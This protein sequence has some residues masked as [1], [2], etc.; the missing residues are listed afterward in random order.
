MSVQV[1]PRMPPLIVSLLLTAGLAAYGIRYYQ[2]RGHESSLLAF[3]S[4]MCILSVSL[5]VETLLHAVTAPGLKLLGFNYLN[6]VG[7]WLSA[8]GFLWFT[9]AYSNS[10]GWLNQWLLAI[11]VA[12]PLV[13]ALP[14]VFAPEYLYTVDG[15]VTQGPMTILGITFQEW[16]L[17]DRTIKQPFLFMIVSVTVVV[18]LGIGVLGRYLYQYRGELY[19]G[20][21][22]AV[23]IG[24]GSPLLTG[25]LLISGLL[26]P[27]ASIT[28]IAYGITAVGFA[29]AIF[30]YR[31]FG[32]APIGRQQLV[33]E[34]AD[35]VIMLDR[36]SHVVD[37][38]PAATALVGEPG[39]WTGLPAA[40]FFSSL[41]SN[42]RRVLLED[43]DITEVSIEF[44]DTIRYFAPDISIIR[45]S[46]GAPKG[47]LIVLRE[48]TSQKEREK[49]LQRQNDRLDQFARTVSHDLRNPLQVAQGHLTLMDADANNEHVATIETAHD[50][51]DQLI[52]EVLTL[53]QV[54]KT[55][56]E[57][58]RVTLEA[59]AT[60][61][62]DHVDFADCECK[63]S[64]PP[65]TT[66]RA[67]YDRLVRVF[68]NLYRNAVQHTDSAVELRVGVLQD[69]ETQ[70]P[71]KQRTG[72]FI[73]D[74]GP[75][76]PE[77]ERA[78]VF[79]NGYTTSADGTG[80]GLSIVENIVDA[81]D[82][83]I[84]VTESS[85]DGARFEISDVEF[86]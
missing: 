27:E 39:E 12:T 5:L 23:A 60:D 63:L 62:M 32:V 79:D 66:I 55:V 47:R 72:F 6:T 1:T 76:I 67:D 8:Y 69:A 25:G 54:G 21:A 81:H 85:E 42:V 11:A 36:E 64:I 9:L 73:E 3:I 71:Q 50:R 33:R 74:T 49:E 44:D 83:D 45:S 10:M 22:A 80:F 84:H 53:A 38:N 78:E 28:G 37:C 51:M 52:D 82:W 16:V 56:E 59:V 34:M 17:L 31:L 70:T 18:L 2:R 58:E 86:C 65:T 20:Q 61:A 7:I 46:R 29:V 26:P 13:F 41:P 30:R 14:T 24:A 4:L 40:E 75:G 35:P 68:E 57:A 19:T 48:I 15:V 77:Q 43:T